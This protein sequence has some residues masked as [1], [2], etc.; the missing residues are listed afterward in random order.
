VATDSSGFHQICL[1]PAA[2]VFRQMLEH[3]A[4]LVPQRFKNRP[5]QVQRPPVEVW[6]NAPVTAADSPRA[7]PTEG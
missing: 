6:I 2:P 3:V 7:T 1:Y 5:P 4:Q